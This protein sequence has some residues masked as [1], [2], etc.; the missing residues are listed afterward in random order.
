M[1]RKKISYLLSKVAQAC[2]FK[3]CVAL[4]IC[5]GPLLVVPRPR[6]LS[7]LPPLITLLA[8]AYVA[9]MI[10]LQGLCFQVSLRGIAGVEMGRS[11]VWLQVVVQDHREGLCHKNSKCPVAPILCAPV[12]PVLGTCK[13]PESTNRSLAGRSLKRHTL[14][15]IATFVCLGNLSQVS[16]LIP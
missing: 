10:S 6:D 14:V 8:H 7:P 5:R 12:L 4:D 16:T 11:W 2:T 3:L 13:G 15:G 9:I 1:G